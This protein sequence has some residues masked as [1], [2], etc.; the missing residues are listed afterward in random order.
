MPRAL[1]SRIC[2]GSLEFCAV[3]F[4]STVT[5]TRSGNRR[6]ALFSCWGS[7]IPPPSCAL[8]ALISKENALSALLRSIP[9]SGECVAHS[10][11]RGLFSPMTSFTHCPGTSFTLPARAEHALGCNR[12]GVEDD[13]CSGTTGA[14]CSG[15]DTEEAEVW[16]SVR[17]LRDLSADRISVAAAISRVGSGRYCRAQPQTASQSGADR[18]GTGAPSG[19]VAAALSRLGC[20]QA[21][22]VAGA[23][24]GGV[25]AQHHPPYSAAS[26][27]GARPRS[28]GRGHATL[29]ARAAQRTVADGL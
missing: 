26:R 10:W 7:A 27:S 8:S 25:A 18:S 20:A 2:A 23:P 13:G 19:R 12:D 22:G 17:G 5:G 16:R 24:G 9:P 14:F 11:V 3:S 1:T 6:A 15:G 28:S 4:R 21:Q 29:R